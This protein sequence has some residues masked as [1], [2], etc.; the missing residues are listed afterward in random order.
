MAAEPSAHLGVPTRSGEDPVRPCQD[1]TPHGMASLMAAPSR[2]GRLGGKGPITMLP[3]LDTDVSAAL[4]CARA[5]D[6]PSRRQVLTY[7][8][9]FAASTILPFQLS[10]ASVS[11]EEL[12]LQAQELTRGV[13]EM[14][15]VAA[16]KRGQAHLNL[17]EA[18]RPNALRNFQLRPLNRAASRTAL[19][20][21]RAS[22]WCGIDEY[23]WIT[24]AET[25][26]GEAGDGPLMAL[27][28]LARAA[29]D[30]MAARSTDCPSPARLTLVTGALRRTGTAPEQASIRASARFELAWEF[31]ANGD[32]HGALM[33]LNAATFE[34]Q[35]AGWPKALIDSSVGTA[36]RKLGRLVDAELALSGALDTP[37]VRRVWILCDLA[38]TYVASGEPD[39]AA[40]A[41]EEAFLL[42]R[43]GG[44]EARLPRILAVRSL[45]PPGRAK[46][47]LVEVMHGI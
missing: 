24:L 21:A 13:E 3:R 14:G 29:A 43:A 27:A 17:I 22:R 28:M 16:L 1:N 36:L 38:R 39:M 42:T 41:L 46:R 18:A 35:S 25:T 40:E 20:C 44:I 31:A 32:Q 33:E 23:R 9:A 11:P 30:G 10:T 6:R 26:A 8:A 37:P 19:V 15:P 4:P 5:M 47:E 2:L 7:A 45:L 34:A 12:E